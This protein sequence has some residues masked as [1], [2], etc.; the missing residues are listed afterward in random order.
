[1][2]EIFIMQESLNLISEYSESYFIRSKDVFCE[3]LLIFLPSVNGKDVYPYYPRVSWGEELSKEYHILYISDPYQPLEQYNE[4][5]GSWFIAP[6][7]VL[8]LDV[9]AEKIEKLAV[10]LNVKSVLFYG[11][12]M[13]GYAAIILASHVDGSMAVAECPQLYLNKHP[14]SRHV[15]EKLLGTDLLL[16][17]FEPLHFLSNAKS[18]RLK[19]ICSA[20][21]HHYTNHIL[22]FIKELAVSDIYMNV[23]FSFETFMNKDYKKG[24]VA[25]HKKHAFKVVADMFSL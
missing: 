4:S 20:Y 9:L 23:D 7:G 19:I 14:G 18:M 2:F 5:K 10:D 12:S 24:H 21:D 8:T 17:E 25:L 11:S 22:P 6:D 16:N 1:M 15:C 13:G 3:K